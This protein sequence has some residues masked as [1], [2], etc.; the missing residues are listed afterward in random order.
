V[1]LRYF[2][3]QCDRRTPQILPARSRRA[4]PR[5]TL[6][7]HCARPPFVKG[8]CHHRLDRRRRY[9]GSGALSRNRLGPRFVAGPSEGETRGRRVSEETKERVKSVDAGRPRDHAHA[10]SRRTGCQ[11]A[12]S[13]RLSWCWQACASPWRAEAA[14]DAVFQLL[15]GLGHQAS[16]LVEPSLSCVIRVGILF[17]RTYRFLGGAWLSWPS[18][19]EVRVG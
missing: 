19:E 9:L 6:A 3:C 14:H 15:L 17:F 5:L 7:F 2:R 4:R 10:P 13:D 8:W 1:G 11:T 18:S 12:W 16:R